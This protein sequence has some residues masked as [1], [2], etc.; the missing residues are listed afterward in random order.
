MKTLLLV[1]TAQIPTAY[2]WYPMAYRL[3]GR[4][5]MGTASSSFVYERFRA[6]AYLAGVGLSFPVP[7]SSQWVYWVMVMLVAPAAASM[8]GAVQACTAREPLIQARDIRS[9]LREQRRTVPP[10]RG[11][12]RSRSVAGSWR[13]QRKIN[14]K[15]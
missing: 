14:R 7:S 5:G 10:A 1:L 13:D 3:L 4:L 2:L 12:G 9:L 11:K 15:S 8:F 6:V